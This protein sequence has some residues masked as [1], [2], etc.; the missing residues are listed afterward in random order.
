MVLVDGSVFGRK[1][2][3]E[4]DF[5]CSVLVLI[6][7]KIGEQY[8]RRFDSDE[9]GGKVLTMGETVNEDGWGLWS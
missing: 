9:Y 4:V 8:E 6:A 5:G 1:M 2:V 7:G 3:M